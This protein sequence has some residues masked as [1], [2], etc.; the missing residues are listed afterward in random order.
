M[1]EKIKNTFQA[2]KLN[3]YALKRLFSLPKDLRKIAEY[4][5]EK[6]WP[7]VGRILKAAWNNR[8]VITRLQNVPDQIESLIPYFLQKDSA[9]EGPNRL[10]SH[11]TM[12]RIAA[13]NVRTA[14]SDVPESIRC[15]L[16][17]QGFKIEYGQTFNEML[18]RKENS[19]VLTSYRRSRRDLGGAPAVY[20]SHYNRAYV[21][22]YYLNQ[23]VSSADAPNLKPRAIMEGMWRANHFAYAD[24]LHEIGHAFDRNVDNIRTRELS[25][26]QTGLVYSRS[27]IRAYRK[28]IAQIG[29]YK[30]SMEIVPY[31]ANKIA[32]IGPSETFAE[33]FAEFFTHHPTPHNLHLVLPNT[34]NWMKTYLHEY[35]I[36][37]HKGGDAHYAFLKSYYSPSKQTDNP[38]KISSPSHAWIKCDETEVDKETHLSRPAHKRVGRYNEKHWIPRGI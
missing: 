22:D 28:D 15:F 17:M 33:L 25:N 27:F 23:N 21:S 36:A 13:M 35:E 37:F 11:G 9:S 32:R 34:M 14:W 29:G 10:Y 4:N 18:S 38:N 26:Q 8:D 5:S 31:F 30:K 16:L 19:D 7:F 1:I 6:P 3:L 20:N 12:T 24:T 2:A